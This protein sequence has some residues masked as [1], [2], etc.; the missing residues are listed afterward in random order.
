MAPL[1][2]AEGVMRGTFAAV[3]LSMAMATHAQ[4]APV[5]IPLQPYGDEAHWTIKAS[6]GGKE[7]D[8]LFDTGGGI[9]AVTPE[10]A[11]AVGCKRWGRI[12]GYRMRGDRVDMDRCDGVELKAAG[13]TLAPET[14]TVW[15]FNAMLP[16][17]APPLG[18]N[19]GL[20]AFGGHVITIDIA[21]RQVILETPLSL[22]ERVAGLARTPS[23]VIRE[24]EG[25]SKTY[26]IRLD[27]SAGPIWMQ[28]D[29]GDDAPITIGK[30]VAALLGLDPEKKG[31]QPLDA[32]L[33]NG[34]PLQG[35]AVVRDIIFDGNIGEP[36]LAKWVLTIDLADGRLW[37]RPNTP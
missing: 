4:A 7:M 3:V 30:H 22:R 17:G 19:L 26:S 28:L 24:A 21:H 23:H 25:Y 32:K 36:I 37:I 16:K 9:T 31:A 15:D 10:V 2:R 20:D 13:A 33:A 27:T 8:F 35:K 34:V 11:K 14:A 1:E 18:G 5:V 12:T 29:S 6:V